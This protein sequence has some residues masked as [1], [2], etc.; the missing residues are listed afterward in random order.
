MYLFRDVDCFYNLSHSHLPS[1]IVL[2]VLPSLF[3]Y[4]FHSFHNEDD[5]IKVIQNEM[6]LQFEGFGSE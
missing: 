3:S 4:F 5:S 1:F 6:R 2:L